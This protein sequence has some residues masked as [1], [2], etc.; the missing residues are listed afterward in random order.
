[1]VSIEKK[2]DRNE[3][4]VL[5]QMCVTATEF[6]PHSD[7]RGHDGN[8]DSS[9]PT[10]P[11]PHDEPLIG[12]GMASNRREKPDV[13]DYPLYNILACLVE[14]AELLKPTADDHWDAVHDCHGY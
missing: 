14:L 3:V 12:P 9:Y 5:V 6:C 8:C 4:V 11:H 13:S 7:L 1:M 10:A 2:R